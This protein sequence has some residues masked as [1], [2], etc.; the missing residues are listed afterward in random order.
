MSNP[1]VILDI[2]PSAHAVTGIRADNQANSVVIITG[3]DAPDAQKLAARCGAVA[4][5]RKPLNDCALLEAI[6]AAIAR[7]G[8]LQSDGEETPRVHKP[9]GDRVAP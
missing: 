4:Y 7:Q 9:K 1:I 5:L 8:S 6:S 2:F 3:D